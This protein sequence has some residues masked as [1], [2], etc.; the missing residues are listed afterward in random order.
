MKSHYLRKSEAYLWRSITALAATGVF[1]FLTVTRF[2]GEDEPVSGSVFLILAIISA[3]LTIR[4]GTEA[5]RCQSIHHKRY[6]EL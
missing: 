1:G 2:K 5:A 3:I 4:F 6:T